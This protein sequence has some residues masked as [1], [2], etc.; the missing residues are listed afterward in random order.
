M[1]EQMTTSVDT[2]TLVLSGITKTYAGV[3]ALTD[4]SFDVRAR[5][6]PR[7]ARRERRRQVDSDERGFG[8]HPARL[9]DDRHRR[10][11]GGPPSTPRLATSLGIA[12]VYQHPAVLE[13]LTV[14]ENIRL[15]VPAEFLK[16]SGSVKQAMQ[17]M[18]DDVASTAHL[19]DRVS[20]LSVA[21]KHLLELAKAL[22]VKP[23]VL[24]LDEPTA[25]L[26]RESVELLFDTGPRRGGGRA[27]PSSTSRTDSPRSASSPTG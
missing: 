16:G 22:V 26:G 18:L 21:Q 3:A 14:A 23:R 19:E 13:D 17:A 8:N 25:P 7:P 27:R 15:A 20:T 9:G 10:R 11:C 2:A 24:I 1:T 5:R 6:G 4:V 12:I